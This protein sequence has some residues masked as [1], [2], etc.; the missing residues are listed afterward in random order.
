MEE[1]G[2]TDQRRFPLRVKSHRLEEISE[3]YFQQMLPKNWTLERRL[4]DY[5]VDLAVEI[6]EGE[7]AK[8]LELL[9]QLKASAEPSGNKTESVTLKTATYNFLWDKL[10]V[11]MLVKY[12]HSEN[13]AYWLFLRD[14]PTP[15]QRCKTFTVHIPKEN[16]LSAAPWEQI[17]AHV[18]RITNC[19]LAARPI[20]P[21]RVD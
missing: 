19:K 7:E 16:R 4:N 9:I 1:F 14:I 3:R 6:F 10:Q 8:G 5:G 15:T 2:M 18:R 11:V 17:Q 12:I 20:R 21:V 13:E